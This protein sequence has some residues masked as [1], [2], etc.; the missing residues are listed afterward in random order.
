MSEYG[1]QIQLTDIV[2][3]QETFTKV[4]GEGAVAMPDP[5]QIT[6]D[7][8]TIAKLEELQGKL[9]TTTVNIEHKG[10]VS[11]D[12]SYTL[13]CAETVKD[14]TAAGYQYDSMGIRINGKLSPTYSPE[15]GDEL[16]GEKVTVTGIM[17]KYYEEDLT[18]DEGENFASYQIV[19]GNRPTSDG[20]NGTEIIVVE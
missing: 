16:V 19:V 7:D 11:K 8:F 9:V 3:A 18:L 2:W 10:N 17:S 6:S 14:L 15:E 12:Y 5:I 13:N 4:E 20:V 1:G